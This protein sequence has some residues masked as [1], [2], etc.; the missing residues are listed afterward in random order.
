MSIIFTT[1][2][3]IIPLIVTIHIRYIYDILCYLY[4]IFIC[5]VPRFLDT[6][7]HYCPIKVIHCVWILLI[8]SL[9]CYS[10][11]VLVSLYYL[12][13]LVGLVNLKI[14]QPIERQT[15]NS[16]QRPQSPQSPYGPYYSNF[17][18]SNSPAFYNYVYG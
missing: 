13:R 9:L 16:P 4:T 10:A 11:S 7:I 15:S 14:N 1:F 2:A 17:Q 18:P 6:L 5:S 3:A 12:V 8:V